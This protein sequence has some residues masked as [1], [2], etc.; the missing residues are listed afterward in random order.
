MTSKTERLY[1]WCGIAGMVLLFAGL[2]LARLLPPP[3]PNESATQVAAF[4]R[5]HTN[6][7]RW[8]SVIMAFGI[9]LLAPWL[10]VVTT[11][12]KR[13]EGIGPATAYCQLALGALLIFEVVL[14]LA[15]LQ[16][17]V[18]R[19]DRSPN[20]TLLLSDLFL[21]LFISPAYT[22]IV[23]LLVTA[24]AI[25]RDHGSHPVFPRWM[26]TVNIGVAVGS[27]PSCFVIFVK[28]GP[29]R[30]SGPIG[31]WVPAAVFGIWVVIMSIGLLTS[32]DASDQESA[33]RAGLPS[34][35]AG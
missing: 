14:P 18:F 12:L 2:I 17:V 35:V 8:G 15:V 29:F 28:T 25:L 21:L 7:L 20:D 16:V 32:E 30:W 9:S 3:S 5:Q 34:V 27:L 13:I 31:F 24:V 6:A 11:R 10:G 23:E 1:V 4:Y 33:G 22:Y 26:A 19:Q